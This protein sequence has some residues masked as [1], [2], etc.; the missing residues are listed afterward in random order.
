MSSHGG[1]FA[2]RKASRARSQS[3]RSSRGSESA[4]R[5]VTKI[6]TSPCCQCGSLWAV[7]SMSPRGSK[8]FMIHANR[9][10]RG[11]SCP[12][13]E[14]A[15]KPRRRRH[16]PAPQVSP[17]IQHWL[18]DQQLRSHSSFIEC[19]NPVLFPNGSGLRLH[20]VQRHVA[21]LPAACE[22]TPDVIGH[23]FQLRN[24]TSKPQRILV[25]V[26]RCSLEMQM[27]GG[28]PVNSL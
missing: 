8:N 21:G 24:A 17:R 11:H 19:A 10:E 18:R 13:F 16:S 26:K 27:F 12:L 7:F 1:G 20:F 25:R 6:A 15:A 5:K 9:G 4:R 28:L 2:A 23:G 14:V 22:L 3:S